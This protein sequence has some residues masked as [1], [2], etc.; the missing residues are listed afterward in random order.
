MILCNKCSWVFLCPNCD[1]GL[2]YHADE[3]LARCHIC[4]FKQAPPVACPECKNPEIIYR[5]M[6]TKAL[7]EEITRLFPDA[8]VRRFDSDNLIGDRLHE[9]YQDILSDKVDI[10]IG[11]QLLAKG[12][13][14][15]R[16]ALVAIVSAETSLALPDFTSEERAFQLLYQI[17][18]RVGRGHTKGEV[19]VQSY[20]PDNI[21]LRS[22]IS[23]DWDSFYNHSLKERQKFRFPPFSYLLQ[24][25][26]KRATENGAQAASEKLLHQLRDKRL[27]VEIMGPAPAFYGRRGKY[28][29][30][31]LIIK[32]KNRDHLVN[33]SKIVPADWVVNIDPTN[34]L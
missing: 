14:L 21:V 23:R 9:N 16:L 31:Q 1:V 8:S 25:T 12:L 4:G 26:C 33:L 15:P 5:S 34:L 6:G 2:I 29:Y 32:S 20:A 7:T 28:F 18:G 22:A 30:Y 27:P 17:I 10:L 13:D 24:L 11:T 19:V 3:H